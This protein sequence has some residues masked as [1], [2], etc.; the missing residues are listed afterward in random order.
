MTFGKVHGI[1]GVS[2]FS[3]LVYTIGGEIIIWARTRILD[4]GSTQTK[5]QDSTENQPL[6]PDSN[7]TEKSST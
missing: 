6:K 5:P 1:Q 3:F 4:A 2:Q 7:S